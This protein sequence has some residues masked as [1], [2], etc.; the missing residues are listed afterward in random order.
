MPPTGRWWP[1]AH[2]TRLSKIRGQ[3]PEARYLARQSCSKPVTDELKPWL[4]EQL[5][6]VSSRSPI[7]EAI[8]Y[9]LTRWNGLTLFLDDGRIEIDNNCIER[10]LEPFACHLKILIDQ[11]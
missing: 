5:R 8:R 11:Y 10:L 6:K 3:S 7:A 9:V 1:P 4:E 2:Q